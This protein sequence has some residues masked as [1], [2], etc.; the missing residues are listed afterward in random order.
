[1]TRFPLRTIL[2][3]GAIS[4]SGVL[5]AP[6]TTKLIRPR[7]MAV[8]DSVQALQSFN[9]SI[10]DSVPESLLP[11]LLPSELLPRA[12]LRWPNW[13]RMRAAVERFQE[14]VTKVIVRRSTKVS[15]QSTE[16]I[17]DTELDHYIPSAQRA[18]EASKIF[19][20]LVEA[21]IKWE[22]EHEDSTDLPKIVALS[23]KEWDFTTTRLNP[24]EDELVKI[25][26][27]KY[28]AENAAKA[29]GIVDA[30]SREVNSLVEEFHS[31]TGLTVTVPNEPDEQ[32]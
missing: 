9:P 15:H 31:I 16:S 2:I 12:K 6:T 19:K 8:V 14:M 11:P 32:H 26:R 4:S 27:G 3:L 25:W 30:L 22:N 28:S 5:A 21:T 24:Q 7:S 18:S 29:D 23:E 1:M 20:A 10:G 13:K 17:E